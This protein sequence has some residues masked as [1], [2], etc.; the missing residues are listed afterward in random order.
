MDCY[1]LVS[2]YRHQIPCLACRAAFLVRFPAAG[3]V[4]A[5]DL[6]H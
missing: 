5:R 2:L 1:R 6:R 4:D 3:P